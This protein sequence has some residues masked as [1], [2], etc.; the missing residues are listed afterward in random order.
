MSK[1]GRGPSDPVN[2]IG[3]IVDQRNTMNHIETQK[4]LLKGWFATGHIKF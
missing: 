3:V 4:G 2:I 1:V